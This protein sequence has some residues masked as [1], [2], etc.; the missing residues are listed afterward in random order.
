MIKTSINLMKVVMDTTMKSNLVF[1]NYYL[2]SRK[3]V[4]SRYKKPYKGVLEYI[5][6]KEYNIL[7]FYRN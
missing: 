3:I 7:L 2:N 5:D 4:L 1:M 6:K